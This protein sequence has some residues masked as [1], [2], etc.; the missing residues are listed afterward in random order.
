MLH[1]DK[2]KCQHA[3]TRSILEFYLINFV[4]E[5]VAIFINATGL[6]VLM[7]SF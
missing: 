5:E 4:I 2:R 7:L 6:G 3:F 1:I